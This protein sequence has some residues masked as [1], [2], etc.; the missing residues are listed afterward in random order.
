MWIN[1]YSATHEDFGQKEQIYSQIFQKLQRVI[2]YCSVFT[3]QYLFGCRH[4]LSFDKRTAFLE[5][6]KQEK[7]RILLER[8]FY[9]FNLSLYNG[10]TANFINMVR[11]P[12]DRIISNFYFVRNPSRWIG[13]EVSPKKSW[14]NKNFDECVTLKDLECMV[15]GMVIYF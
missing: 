8:H 7:K 6:V 9:Y 4:F 13:R 14:I 2:F 10:Q 5:I 12:V 15:C 3:I 1:W 11:H